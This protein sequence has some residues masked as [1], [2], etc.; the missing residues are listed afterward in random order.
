M[1]WVS[2]YRHA[3]VAANSTFAAAQPLWSAATYLACRRFG[4]GAKR[5]AASYGH[6]CKSER[7]REARDAAESSASL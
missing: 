7:Q 5:P 3:K 1:S 4:F 6:R 2:K